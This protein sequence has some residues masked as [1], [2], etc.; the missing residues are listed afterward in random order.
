[1]TFR[2][3][4]SHV[5]FRKN[6]FGDRS[7]LYARAHT[8]KA[9]CNNAR[10]KDDDKKRFLSFFLSFPVCLSV[11]LSCPSCVSRDDDP[12]IELEKS[13]REEE[14]R[15]IENKIKCFRCTK[16]GRTWK[17]STPERPRFASTTRVV[18]SR[19]GGI[20]RVSPERDI[21]AHPAWVFVH[22]SRSPRRSRRL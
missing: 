18:T 15:D 19:L 1:M 7:L 14:K 20:P 21:R 9:L 6:P 13:Q 2:R 5:A 12:K 8:K 17:R 4:P 10:E 11:C 3:M 16:A 22:T